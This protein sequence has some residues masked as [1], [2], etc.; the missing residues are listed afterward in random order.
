MPLVMMTE[1]ELGDLAVCYIHVE[2]YTDMRAIYHVLSREYPGQF[3][4]KTAL[5]VIS[6]ALKDERKQEHA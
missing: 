1:K 2:G 3:D 6:R 5:A 4:R